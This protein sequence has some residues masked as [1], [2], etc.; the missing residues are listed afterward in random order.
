MV[1]FIMGLTI[2]QN[3]MRGESIMEEIRKFFKD[4]TGLEAVTISRISFTEYMVEAED[5]NIYY[6]H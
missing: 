2:V 4:Q 5:G 1:R 6:I 3:G